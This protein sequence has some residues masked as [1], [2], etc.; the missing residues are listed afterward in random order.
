MEAQGSRE[1]VGRLRPPTPLPAATGSGNSSCATALD[2]C[3]D[4]VERATQTLDWATTYGGGPLTIALDHL[5]LARAALYG[6]LV[7]T[8]ADLAPAATPPGP[9]VA[10][11]LANIRRANRVDC[12]PMALLT[13]AAVP[14]DS[15]R[16]IRSRPAGRW[17]RG[18]QIAERGPM[19]LHLADVC[20]A[21]ASFR[22][23]RVDR[24][25]R[26]MVHP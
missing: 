15:G 13:V 5:T 19:P 16:A 23:S 11:A 3:A 25:L 2:A 26:L 9:G 18:A 1:C 22:P 12:L 20:T 24:G 14:R 10:A 7:G 17:S 4:V 21:P 8:R 6:A